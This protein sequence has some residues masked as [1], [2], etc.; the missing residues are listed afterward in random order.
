MSNIKAKTLVD[1]LWNWMSTYKGK[2]VVK[3]TTNVFSI[4]AD[5]YID[6][7]VS[8]PL[9]FTMFELSDSGELMLEDIGKLIESKAAYFMFLNPKTGWM[10]MIKNTTENV[11]KLGKGEPLQGMKVKIIS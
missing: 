10:V 7:T 8:E 3:D 5:C 11:G 9:S 4:K 1:S 6:S 2:P